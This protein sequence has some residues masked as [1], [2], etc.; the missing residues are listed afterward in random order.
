MQSFYLPKPILEKLDKTYRNF[1]WN[2]DPLCSSTDLIGWNHICKPKCFGGFGI[3]KADTNN[4]TLQL[5]LLWKLLKDEDTLWVKLVLRKYVKNQSLMSHKHSN[6]ASWQWKH[7][8]RLQPIFC[9]RLRW[10]VGD[11]TQISFWFDNR[12]LQYPI[13]DLVVPSPGSQH[14]RVYDFLNPGGS[15]D[16]PKLE[17]FLLPVLVSKI[18]SLFVSSNP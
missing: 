16:Q 15:W 13:K 10:Q 3:R 12:I 7:L 1:F 2:K 14:M 9:K 8:M 4:I 5:K 6:V 11:V 18:S 17:Y